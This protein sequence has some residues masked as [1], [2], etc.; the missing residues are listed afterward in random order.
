MDQQWDLGLKQLVRRK[1]QQ[2]VQRMDQL[3]ARQWDQGLKQLVRR[4]ALH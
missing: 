4:K 1:D 3:R 2:T